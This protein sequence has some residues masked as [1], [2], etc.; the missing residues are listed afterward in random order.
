M[1]LGSFTWRHIQFKPEIRRCPF[2]CFRWFYICQVPESTW[3]VSTLS[4]A[5]MEIMSMYA[6]RF[7][8]TSA[9]GNCSFADK[10]IPSFSTTRLGQET[11]VTYI[12]TV[13]HKETFVDNFNSVHWSRIHALSCV[14]ITSGMYCANWQKKLLSLKYR[15]VPSQEVGQ[16]KPF[17][18]LLSLQ[19]R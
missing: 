10:H 5:D 9:L 7:S 14:I 2:G 3:R 19:S 15:P 12:N 18:N 8:T 1:K 13:Y 4:F 16:W 17:A 11:D 6:C